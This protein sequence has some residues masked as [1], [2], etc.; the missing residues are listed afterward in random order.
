MVKLIIVLSAVAG[1]YWALGQV[2]HF[3]S[4]AFGVGGLGVTYVALGTIVVVFLAYRSVK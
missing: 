3:R 2:N 4:F 1:A